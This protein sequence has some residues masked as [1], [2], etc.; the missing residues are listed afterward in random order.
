[1]YKID[2]AAGFPSELAIQENAW[3][4]ARQASISQSQGLV[5][6][7]EPEILADGE[8]GIE[9]CAA[10]T[11]RVQAAVTKALHD[12]KIIWEGCLLKPNMVTPGFGAPRATPADVAWYTVRTL[13]RTMPAALGGV[14]FLSGGFSEE[15]ASCYLSAMNKL[16]AKLRPWSLSFSYGRALQQS[17]L[18]TWKGSAE[19]VEAAK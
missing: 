17:A 13:R 12:N 5:P 18:K 15:E 2:Q 10:I 7:V 11:E 6:I 4:L 3:V 19:N 1:M 14:N 8:H 16:D 9:V